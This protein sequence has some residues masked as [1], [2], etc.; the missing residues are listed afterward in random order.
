MSEK[1]KIG[2]VVK[3]KSG[4]VPMVVVDAGQDIDDNDVAEL[5]WHDVHGVPQVLDDIPTLC[6]VV[7]PQ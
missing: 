5:M 1:V 2:D 3:L 7:Q 4:G 6:L